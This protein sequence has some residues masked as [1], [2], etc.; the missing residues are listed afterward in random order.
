MLLFFIKFSNGGFFMSDIFA[1]LLAFFGIAGAPA[2]FSE[3]VP[4]FFAVLVALGLFLFLFNMIR[5]VVS[6]TQHL[7]R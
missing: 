2:N 7:A 4:W 1:Q 3:F 6:M 5:A